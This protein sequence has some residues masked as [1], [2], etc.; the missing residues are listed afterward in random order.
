MVTAT[1]ILK[2]VIQVVDKATAGMKQ[3]EKG[4]AAIDKNLKQ[5]RRSG[6]GYLG[7]GFALLFQGMALQRVFGKFLRSAFEGYK[8]VIDVNDIFFQKVQQLRAGWEFF[9]FS[10]MDALLQSE[11]FASFLNFLQGIVDRLGSMSDESKAGFGNIALGAFIVFGALSILGAVILT[12]GSFAGVLGLGFWALSGKLALVALWAL[13]LIAAFTF[14]NNDVMTPLEKTITAVGIALFVFAL[15]FL[16]ASLA[17]TA[18]V[19]LLG[20]FLILIGLLSVKFGG[21]WNAFRAMLA[22]ILMGLAILFDAWVNFWI[23]PMQIIAKGIVALIRAM[24]G[25]APLALAKFAHMGLDITGTAAELL[26]GLQPTIVEE[27]PISAIADDMGKQVKEGVIGALGGLGKIIA[28]EM[29]DVLD[30]KFPAPETNFEDLVAQQNEK[31]LGIVDKT[32]EKAG[33]KMAEA[34]EK[35]LADNVVMIPTTQR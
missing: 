5:A 26:V 32:V 10:M 14:L 1:H 15:L 22:N 11:L 28:D 4:T 8:Q 13:I 29:S 27:K 18:M 3:A 33:E 19:L 21:L 6:M 31:M 9:K 23:K 12:V 20:I 24:G 7:V 17:V 34:I 35:N 2:I 25:V 30:E 16:T